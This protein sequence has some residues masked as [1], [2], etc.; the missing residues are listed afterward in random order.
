MHH[1]QDKDVVQLT[2]GY[3]QLEGRRVQLKKPFAILEKVG[4]RSDHRI[5]WN[6]LMEA[7]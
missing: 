3:H 4:S 1:L 6:M 5:A 7:C 2:I